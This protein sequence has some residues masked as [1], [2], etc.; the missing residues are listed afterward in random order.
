MISW[1]ILLHCP[2]FITQLINEF[3]PLPYFI[4]Y[5]D[6]TTRFSVWLF[7]QYLRFHLHLDLDE[8]GQIGCYFLF[9]QTIESSVAN[10]E[11]DVAVQRFYSM[12][13]RQDASTPASASLTPTPSFSRRQR[14]VN[15]HVKFPIGPT[16]A[17]VCR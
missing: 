5:L 11:E 13:Q 17:M 12:T 15:A 9:L 3:S 2:V 14:C 10:A 4:H 6:C 16:V 7:A 8:V 1:L